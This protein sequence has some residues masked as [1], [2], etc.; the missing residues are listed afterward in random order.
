MGN[1]VTNIGF[2]GISKSIWRDPRTW[3]FLLAITEK[4]LFRY[5]LLVLDVATGTE[6]IRD[7][8]LHTAY[9][10]VIALCLK[11]GSK[12]QMSDIFIML[13]VVLSIFLTWLLY[14]ENIEKYMFGEDQFWPTVFPLFRFFIVGLF[15]I[16]KDETM[17]LMGKVSCIAILVEIYFLLFYLRGTDLQRNDD[18]SRAYF[19]LLNVLLVINYAFDKKTFVGIVMSVVGIMLLLSMGTRGPIMI[20]LAFI[21]LR[22]I[23]NSTNKGGKGVVVVILLFLM[24]FVNSPYW[25]FFLIFLQGVL[26]SLGMSTRVI[27]FTIEG[28]TLTYYSERDEIAEIVMS[29]IKERPFEGWGVYGEWQFVGWSAHNMYLE[30]L[31]HYGVIIGGIILLWMVFISVKAFFVAKIPMVRSLVLLLISF[32]FVRGIFG[33][34]FLTSATFL[35]IGF[36]L[37]VCRKTNFKYLP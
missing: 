4:S 8:V 37:Q 29:K 31:D 16:P 18:M 5:V 28:E 20:V 27:D 11:K 24:C 10:I 14:P 17:T 25:N 13:F 35:M 7:I 6:L 12:F 3:L 30:I 36:C 1:T 34:G 23:Q 19:M 2:L 32:V 22:I 9:I 15:I 33:G 26:D 21:A